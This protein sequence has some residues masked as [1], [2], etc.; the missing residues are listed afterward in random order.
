M[1]TGRITGQFAPEVSRLRDGLTNMERFHISAL[2]NNTNTMSPETSGNNRPVKQRHIPEELIP[3]AF[4]KG[5][6]HP[7][8]C[9]CSH[10]G[11]A[12]I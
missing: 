12:K 5:K 10:T 3:L 6:D 9:L 4:I 11:L 1:V 7:I 8:T 2:E